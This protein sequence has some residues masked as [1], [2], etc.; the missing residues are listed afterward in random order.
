MKKSQKK[1][2]NGVNS[3]LDDASAKNAGGGA[4]E[5]S[6]KTA[7]E[8]STNS[9][10]SNLRGENKTASNSNLGANGDKVKLTVAPILPRVMAFVVDMFMVAIPLLY[11]A[12]YVIAS[13]KDGFQQNQPLIAL[14]Q[15]LIAVIL[16]GLLARGAQTLGYRRYGLYALTLGG[17]RA[18][19]WRYLWRY[20]LFA[21]LFVV[22]GSLVAVFRRDHR[23]LHDILSGIIVLAKKAQ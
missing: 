1:N 21:A 6:A 9:S 4:G 19:F 22:G 3:N 13:G 18:G 16:C 10:N 20:F 23:A 14:V 12:A 15:L 5:K 7:S 8:K 2:K 17:K 11:I